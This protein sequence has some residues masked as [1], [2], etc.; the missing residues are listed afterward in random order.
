MGLRGTRLGF[1]P[2]LVCVAAL[3]FMVGCEE[4]G[5][6]TPTPL[7]R[8]GSAWHQHVFAFGGDGE[9]EAKAKALT[10]A[11][12]FWHSDDYSGTMTLEQTGSNV[13][14]RLSDDD[15]SAPVDGTYDGKTVLLRIHAGGT[16]TM[17]LTGTYNV[18]AEAM[19]GTFFE[20]ARKLT[21]PALGTWGA[22]RID[23]E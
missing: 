1:W 8:T 9:G 14:G 4:D 10:G 13:V 11:W 6:T 18:Q 2:S 19:G 17:D 3:V 7:A 16:D 22:V 12:A 23:T 15:G 21:K 5:T 20:I